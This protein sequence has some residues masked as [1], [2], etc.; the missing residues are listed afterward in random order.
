LGSEVDYVPIVG[1]LDP[2]AESGRPDRLVTFFE[3][4]VG[5]ELDQ[6]PAHR[7]WPQLNGWEVNRGACYAGAER[8]QEVIDGSSD[9]HAPATSDATEPRSGECRKELR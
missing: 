1:L 6:I 9:H 2:T 3:Q 5:I 8:N 7:P 4:N